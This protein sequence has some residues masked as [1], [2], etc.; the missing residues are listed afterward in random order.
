MSKSARPLVR[1]LAAAVACVAFTA[2]AVHA[3]APIGSP[4]STTNRHTPR[5]PIPAG[6]AYWQCSTDCTVKLDS[7]AQV[8]AREPDAAAPALVPSAPFRR[9]P[10]QAVRRARAVL[11]DVMFGWYD[12]SDRADHYRFGRPTGEP[13][14]RKGDN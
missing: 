4:L 2:P 10:P 14:V 3:Q 5:N 7:V 9:V 12:K 6:K 11:D 1:A 13:L 8:R